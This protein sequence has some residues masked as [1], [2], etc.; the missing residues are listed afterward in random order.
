MQCNHYRGGFRVHTHVNMTAFMWSVCS[1][2]LVFIYAAQVRTCLHLHVP[3]CASAYERAFVSECVYS[4]GP[5]SVSGGPD[6]N[7][8]SPVLFA[9]DMPQEAKTTV[10][11]CPG[12]RTSLNTPDSCILRE[13]RHCVQCFY[14][15]ILWNLLD[16]VILVN[17]FL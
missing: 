7:Q 14:T 11:V 5:R 1:R 13:C 2:V 8:S 4:V 12:L 3:K 16:H 15:F 10:R 9:Q 17:L 6:L